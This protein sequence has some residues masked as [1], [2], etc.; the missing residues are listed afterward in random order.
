MINKNQNLI[1]IPSF[2]LND[3]QKKKFSL[4]G[5]VYLALKGKFLSFTIRNLTGKY[6]C[7]IINFFYGKNGYIR[8]ENSLYYKKING[9]NF[10]Y[11]NKRF[12]RI[13]NDE[14]ILFDII[15]QSYCLNS[16]DFTNNDIVIDCGANVGELKLAINQRNKDIE[17]YAFEPDALVFECLLKNFPTYSKNLYNLGLSNDNSLKK[18]FADSEGGNSSFIDFGSKDIREVQCITLD[19]LNLKKEIKLFKVEAE[20]YEPEVLLG[21]VNTLK[22]VEFVAVDFGPERGKGQSNTVVEVNNIL[23]ENNFSLVNFSNFR[24]AGLYRNN[25]ITNND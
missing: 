4:L 11:P 22:K 15:N 23:Y 8:Y 20:G 10:Y 7:V 12:L 25:K 17:Y 24:A 1:N 9:L 19:S 14:K 21:S 6:L 3:L 13:V 5:K 2:V 18:L 16:I